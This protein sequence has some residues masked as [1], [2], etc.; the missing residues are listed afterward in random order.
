MDLSPFVSTPPILT[1]SDVKQLVR[2]QRLGFSAIAKELQ[3]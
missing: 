3:H 1:F 2:L